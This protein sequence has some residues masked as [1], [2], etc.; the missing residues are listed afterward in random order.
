VSLLLARTDHQVVSRS[1]AGVAQRPVETTQPDR[2]RERGARLL[3]DRYAVGDPIGRG[4]STV[5]SGRDVRLRR[6]VAIKR[7]QLDAGPEAAG[8]TRLRAMREAQAAAR[9]SNPRAVTVFDVV[10]E[11]ESIWLVME[12]VDAPSLAALVVE[13]G[14]L[15]HRRAAAIGI[16]VLDALDAAHAVGVVHRDVKPANVLVGP[17]D[18]AK[19]TDFGVARIRD[20]SRLTVT[21]HIIGSPAYMAPE[22]AR[23]ERV[24]P[25]ADLWSLGATLYFAVEGV[26]PFPGTSA[27][28]V[29]T[30]VVH[31]R[32]RLPARP[33]PLTDIVDRLLSKDPVDRPAAGEIR[34]ALQSV[35]RS[36]TP[37]RPDASAVDPGDGPAVTPSSP[38]RSAPPDDPV[39]TETEV[40]PAL[41]EPGPALADVPALLEAAELSTPAGDVAV[42]SPASAGPSPKGQVV[43]AG[44]PDA[45]ARAGVRAGPVRAGEAAERDRHRDRA[46]AVRP[47]GA[48]VGTPR[49]PAGSSFDED[50]VIVGSEG[51][52]TAGPAAPP[53]STGAGQATRR[54]ERTAARRPSTREGG[55]R[56]RLAGLVLAALAAVGIVALVVPRVSDEG[57]EGASDQSVNDQSVNDQSV[58]DQATTEATSGTTGGTPTSADSPTTTAATTRTAPTG[59]TTTTGTGGAE[60]PTTGTSGSRVPDGWT[61]FTDP[62]GAYTIAHPPGWSVVRGSRDHTAYFREPGTGTYL[63]VEWTPE[64]RPDPVADW[65]EQS[66]YFGDRH[67]GY[68]ELRIEPYTYRDYDAAMWEFRY[69]DG[70]AVLHTGN[71]GFL[72]EGRGYALYFQTR[73]QNWDSGQDTYAQFREAFSPA[74]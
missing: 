61:S 46:A 17:G 41:V 45:G 1:S 22:Q 49:A 36:R 65:Q 74:P 35:R 6:R 59:A 14:P 7:V 32:H 43:R 67:E 50:V 42:P 3:A 16:D 11:A 71:L 33:G 5:Y 21:G 62:E 20:D 12:L 30:A 44:S 56:G 8:A 54:R 13:Q 55:P 70:G 26:T 4:R 18:R 31:R 23:G 72:T 38:P 37:D 73:E 24:G 9:L 58:N 53:V 40:F 25:A 10:E 68:E 29:A 60:E 19:L 51:P 66:H 28:A 34:R 48:L 47:S 2:D 63:L 69:R 52:P 57:G 27:I 64:P 39:G 15:G